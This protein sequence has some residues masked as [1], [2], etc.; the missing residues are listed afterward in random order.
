MAWTCCD[1]ADTLLQRAE[2]GD[3]HLS[4]IPVK[5]ATRIGKEGDKDHMLAVT[6][7]TEVLRFQS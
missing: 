1:Y 3:R 6:L 4:A 7:V 5:P 2:P